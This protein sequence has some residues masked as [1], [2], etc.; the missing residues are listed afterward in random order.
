MY[1]IV[2]GVLLILAG[3]SVVGSRLEWRRQ[4]RRELKGKWREDDVSRAERGGTRAE[5]RQIEEIIELKDIR[6]NPL[7]RQDKRGWENAGEGSSRMG[8]RRRSSRAELTPWS[9]EGRLTLVKELEKIQGLSYERA[10]M[11]AFDRAAS[12]DGRK[13]RSNL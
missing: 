10:K 12:L 11:Q 8:R 2:Q 9:L 4:V 7:V 5:T 1:A 6:P 3:L 13:I